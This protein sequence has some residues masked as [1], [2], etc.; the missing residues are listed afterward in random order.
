MKGT[1]PRTNHK[2]GTCKYKLLTPMQ[3]CAQTQ[4]HNSRW[5]HRCCICRPVLSCPAL[6]D[7]IY[8]QL[9]AFAVSTLLSVL[10][11]QPFNIFDFT[12]LTDSTNSTI[13]LVFYRY[14]QSAWPGPAWP[15]ILMNSLMCWLQFIVAFIKSSSL[16]FIIFY[17][18]AIFF[19]V[20]CF[21]FS[22]LFLLLIIKRKH[23]HNN[24]PFYIVNKVQ[25]A[26]C[27]CYSFIF[28][29]C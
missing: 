8:R 28:N 15:G 19:F 11:P 26:T 20:F 16:L 18:F 14:T 4:S 10:L 21:C 24:C 7:C 17:L 2:I 13:L 3:K 5:L 1:P 6:S 22:S 25:A 29:L 23:N 12:N 9:V 27:G